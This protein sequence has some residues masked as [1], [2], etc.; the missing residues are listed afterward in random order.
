MDTL[1]PAERSAR[2][3]LIRSKD[4][5]FEL[6]VRTALH[7][8][9]YRYRKHD[10]KLPGRPDLVFAARHK[11]IFLHGCFWHGHHCRLGRMPKS[12]AYYWVP[13]IAGNRARDKRNIRSLRALGW[14][15]LTVWEC[16]LSNFDELF[17]RI[18]RFLEKT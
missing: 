11:A 6:R 4:S 2:M 9:G 16:Q 12:R 17:T 18:Q 7:K 14:S 13:K 1:A 3:A 8:R 15:S 10:P 5:K